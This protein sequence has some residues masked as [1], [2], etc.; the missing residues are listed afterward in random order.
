MVVKDLACNSQWSELHPAINGETE[1]DFMWQ[2]MTVFIIQDNC[3]GGSIENGLK[4]KDKFKE[5]LGGV[6]L[7]RLKNNKGFPEV[8]KQRGSIP[9]LRQ[10]L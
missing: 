8:R 7:L 9:F 1:K 3:S 5:Q 6:L 10:N 2:S 4:K